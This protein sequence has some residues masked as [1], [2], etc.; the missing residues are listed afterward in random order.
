MSQD[1]VPIDKTF[2]QA[3]ATIFNKDIILIP[4]DGGGEYDFVQ[5]GLN[6]GKSKGNPLYLGH[7]QKTE[8]CPDIF[9][10][11]MPETIDNEKVSNI[12]AG[13]MKIAD[14]HII[15]NNEEDNKNSGHEV[16]DHSIDSATD[17]PIEIEN[18]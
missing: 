10:S 15:L 11:V 18:P 5:G 2:I 12:L 4:V 17:N 16:T 6:N 9:V 7:I 14:N 13:D 8:N 3:V 1:G